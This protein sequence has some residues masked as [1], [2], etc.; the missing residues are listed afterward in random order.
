[1]VTTDTTKGNASR[2]PM[3][4]PCSD[5]TAGFSG[6]TSISAVQ[7]LFSDDSDSQEERMYGSVLLQCVQTFDPSDE[8][9]AEI[10]RQVA[11]S[12]V[13]NGSRQEEYKE[14]LDMSRP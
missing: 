5:S 8:V 1:M 6:Y 4:V 13:C 14:I 9:S 7:C 11:E 10:D 2:Q 12:H 3:Q